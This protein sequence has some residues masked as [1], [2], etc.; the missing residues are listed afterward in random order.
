MNNTNY[1]PLIDGM[2][3]SYSRLSSFESCPYGWK[4]KYIDKEKDEP[5]FYTS[6]GSYVHK[7]LQ[8]YYDGFL[9]S[10]DLKYQ[11]LLGFQNNVIG[12]R[13]QQSIV[14]KYIESGKSYFESFKPFDMRTIAV[15]KDASFNIGDMKCIGFVDY[16]GEKDGNLYIVDHKSRELKNRSGRKK[17]TKNDE[18]IDSM[19]KQLYIYSIDIENTFGT[20]PSYLCFNCFRNGEFIK[21]PFDNAAFESAKQW[22]VDT[23][24]WIS[25]TSDFYPTLNYFY[26]RYLCGLHNK[27]FYYDIE[28]GGKGD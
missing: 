7:L 28:Y 23:K 21:E 22:A 9:S 18:L 3:W 17:P 16:V 11:F 1:K 10:S 20:K 15:E 14:E 5:M 12:E 24:D 13:P 2:T 4:L 25:R 26:C 8:M 6:Y 27:C 19:L